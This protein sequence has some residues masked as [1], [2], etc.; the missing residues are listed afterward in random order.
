MSLVHIVRSLLILATFYCLFKGQRKL[1]LV[2][3]ATAIVY[4]IVFSKSVGCHME[5]DGRAN[6]LVCP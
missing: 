2:L 6:P 1:A 3:L 5:W 4:S